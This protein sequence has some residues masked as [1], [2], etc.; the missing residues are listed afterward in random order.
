[1]SFPHIDFGRAFSEPVAE[2][3]YLPPATPV[4]KSLS[5]LVKATLI[6]STR[7]VNNLPDK[8]KNEVRTL[9]ERFQ[10]FTA[11]V[12]ALF[13]AMYKTGVV[14][15][16]DMEEI[17][18]Y[19]LEFA[20]MSLESSVLPRAD[21]PKATAKIKEMQKHLLEIKEFGVD[22]K[23]LATLQEQFDALSTQ[24]TDCINSPVYPGEPLSH[25]TLANLH[26]TTRKL[27]QYQKAVEALPEDS[28]S[29]IRENWAFQRTAAFFSSV[30]LSMWQ[31]KLK[32][33]LDNEASYLKKALKTDPQN[34]DLLRQLHAFHLQ[35]DA[36]VKELQSLHR[37]VARV[38]ELA[39]IAQD[40]QVALQTVEKSRAS[41][42]K[43]HGER[44]TKPTRYTLQFGSPEWVDFVRARPEER[45]GLLSRT[46]N[47][48]SP[49]NWSDQTKDIVY[50]LFATSQLA[51]QAARVSEQMQQGSRLQ[52]AAEE[53]QKQ[54]MKAVPADQVE[55]IERETFFLGRLLADKYVSLNKDEIILKLTAHYPNIREVINQVREQFGT[56]SPTHQQVFVIM[57]AYRTEQLV[58]AS[59]I[60]NPF[61]HLSFAQWWTILTNSEGTFP[62]VE[63]APKPLSEHAIALRKE[64]SA[65]VALMMLQLGAATASVA[66][67]YMSQRLERIRD[68]S[69]K[70]ESLLD[71]FPDN[72]LGDWLQLRKH[73]SFLHSK[74]IDSIRETPPESS[75]L[76]ELAVWLQ[77]VDDVCY[78]ISN[79]ENQL[80]AWMGEIEEISQHRQEYDALLA[81]HRNFRDEKTQLALP[82]MERLKTLLRT[83]KEPD[84]ILI[85]GDVLDAAAKGLMQDNLAMRTSAIDLI[86]ALLA[87]RQGLEGILEK[88]LSIA[89]KELA[90]KEV[91]RKKDALKLYAL[92]AQHDGAEEKVIEAAKT[93]MKHEDGK[94][95]SL[96]QDVFNELLF[97]QVRN[98][99]GKGYAHYIPDPEPRVKALKL[100]AELVPITNLAS[101][102]A[103]NKAHLIL[104]DEL[105]D[106]NDAVRAEAIHLLHQLIKHRPWDLS[107]ENH[108]SLSFDA[109]RKVADRET[110]KELYKELH[111]S[112]PYAAKLIDLYPY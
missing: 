105:T 110:R 46:V 106:P 52:S 44:L 47:H 33:A 100:F 54:V 62:N 112:N 11:R 72:A 22:L 84:L 13:S 109:V 69:Q 19:S 30:T 43:Q 53:M 83:G 21:Q 31:T 67:T 70:M 88:L 28:V 96:A 9:N 10:F 51:A 23:R 35:Q 86:E 77:H 34:E 65:K 50:R 4:S 2:S 58:K 40:I 95:R 20:T 92:M 103:W 87:R 55:K 71:K 108:G 80:S 79:I 93:G 76:H 27:Y 32:S 16:R 42:E 26:D 49:A 61:Q 107:I 64:Q 3:R 17:D 25:A 8:Q 1:M 78:G 29:Q 75:S 68:F 6:G 63:T 81:A 5:Q 82:Y 41:V 89:E 85:E 24:F 91:Q 36:V 97:K 57:D 60:A 48:L 38:P 45:Q 104:K 7:A 18:A 98:L 39:P 15:P 94:V 66:N 73:I 99:S 101:S 111:Q 102:V 90:A 12:T 37:L 56:L 59:P 74:L 14:T